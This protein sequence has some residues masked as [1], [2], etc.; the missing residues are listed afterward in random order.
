[1]VLDDRFLA[2]LGYSREDAWLCDLLPESRLNA[3]QRRA[4]DRAY[5]PFVNQGLLPTATI[6][7]VPPRFCDDE[8]AAQIVDE[9]LTSQAEILVTLGDIPLGQFVARFEPTWSRL[10]VFGRS[11]DLYGQLHP[12]NLGGHSLSLLPLVHPRQAGRLGASSGAWGDLHDLWGRA[13]RGS[14]AAY[15][16]ALAQVPHAES[17]PADRKEGL[18]EGVRPRRG[19]LNPGSI[20]TT[21]DFDHPLPDEFWVG[22]HQT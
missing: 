17:D 16:A 22:S 2:P 5:L 13:N 19:N 7:P 15:E 8:R 3:S 1:M 14:R 12:F 11:P 4:I 10:S 6:P 18:Q 20:I 9:I 21:D